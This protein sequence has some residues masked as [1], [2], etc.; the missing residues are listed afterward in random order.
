MK[1]NTFLKIIGFLIILSFLSI[2]SWVSIEA[3]IEA[4]SGEAFCG[5]CHPMDPMIDSFLESTHGGNNEHGVMAACTDCHISHENPFLHLLGKAKAGSHDVWVMITED[6][7]QIDWSS[8]R[9]RREEFVY[10]SGCKTCH[11]NLEDATMGNT[12]AFV[13]HKPYFLSETDDQC[14]SCHQ[15]VGHKNL[16][17]YINQ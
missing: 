2:G 16:D 13:A 8:T 7:D 10:D 4:T 14:V 3:T 6:T 12:K 1:K 9:Q 11:K 17:H 5:S 15:Y